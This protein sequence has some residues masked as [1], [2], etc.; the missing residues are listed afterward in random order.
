MSFL[1]SDPEAAAVRRA[2][3]AYLPEL[4]YETARIRRMRERHDL[5][6]LDE[7]LTSLSARLARAAEADA[8]AATLP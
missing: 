4:R 8:A 5:V 6:H 2:L 1:L 3:D 7:I